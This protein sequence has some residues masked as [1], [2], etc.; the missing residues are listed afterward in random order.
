MA[1][2]DIW[3]VEN[4]RVGDLLP[5]KQNPRKIS[6]EKLEKLKQRIESQGIRVPPSIAINGTILAGHQRIKA[7]IDLYGED[8]MIPVVVANKELTD[9]QIQEIV[10]TD[11][12]SWGEFDWDNEFWLSTDEDELRLWGFDDIGFNFDAVDNATNSEEEELVDMDST[13]SVTQ[14]GDIWLLGEHRLMCGDSVD[15]A[16]VDKLINGLEVDMVY[17]DPPYGVS[18]VQV[19]GKVSPGMAP[20]PALRGKIG[21][22]KPFGK[23]FDS[24]GM[25][26]KPIIEANT[27]APIIGDDTTETA[28]KSY[29][30][31]ADLKIP[32]MIFWGGNYY[33]SSLPDSSCWIVWDKDNGVSFFADAE[34]AWT[35]QKTAV[36][37]CKHTWN[38]LIKESERNEKRVHPTQK[39]IALAEWC[40]SKYGEDAEIVL[41]LFLGSGS[42]LIACEKMEKI[43]I[44]MEMSPD[45]CD[46]IIKRWQKFT[47]KEAILEST[48]DTYNS[49][50]PKQHA[51][52]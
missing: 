8:T 20:G 47:G 41:D 26:K 3:Q 19:D 12:L 17:T 34:L 38:G 42:T 9:K 43:C 44:G 6:P 30:I 7:I 24:K 15:K 45:Y 32:I 40:I 49:K 28:I 36:R 11:N 25:K 5:Y 37:I 13:D 1:D 10:A 16:D 50:A 29:Q 23:V 4:M 27:Y 21:G 46:V 52:N 18:I 2:A 35:N 39:P 48:G 22:D 51:S 33:A 14:Y 31:C